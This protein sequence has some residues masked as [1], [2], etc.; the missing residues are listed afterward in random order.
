MSSLAEILAARDARRSRQLELLA[1]YPEKALVVLTVVLP[2][3]VKRN[4][5]SLLIAREAW[6]TLD[7]CF[8]RLTLHAEQH[9]LDTGFEGYRV[10]DL[11]PRAA[12]LLTLQIEDEHPLGRLFDLDV[13]L[14]GGIPLSREAMGRPPRRC[15][16][17]NEA[18]RFCMRNH[19]HSLND[20]LAHVDR[21]IA[22]YV[23]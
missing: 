17:C 7:E 8:A 23:G 3:S 10:V 4:A 18:A 6:R 22:D 19:T 21:M 20:L 9:D 11:E 12:K 13:V 2:G 15:M 5:Q 14:P 1:E 16:L